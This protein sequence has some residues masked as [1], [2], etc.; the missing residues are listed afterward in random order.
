MYFRTDVL[1][2]LGF[3]R[4]TRR[5]PTRVRANSEPNIWLF[6]KWY[7]TCP[8]NSRG[9]VGDEKKIKLLDVVLRNQ[10]TLKEMC[11]NKVKQIVRK[12]IFI[13]RWLNVDCKRCNEW[14]SSVK[15]EYWSSVLYKMFTMFNLLYKTV[16]VKFSGWQSL[17]QVYYHAMC[18]NQPIPHS[19]YPCAQF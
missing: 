3:F 12:W 4:Y 19:Q 5:A 6:A 9:W 10:Q 13:W 11:S 14:W 16:T 15:T 2:Y 18:D 1:E 8:K 7:L 17:W